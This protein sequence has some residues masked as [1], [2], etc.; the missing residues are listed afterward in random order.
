MTAGGNQRLL[1]FNA[2]ITFPIS[3]GGSSLVRPLDQGSD[4]VTAD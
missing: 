3:G 2:A 4:L 1:A